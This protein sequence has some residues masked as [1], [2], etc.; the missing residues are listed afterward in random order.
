LIALTILKVLGA[1][2]L[3]DVAL[4]L[5]RAMQARMAGAMAGRPA[6]RTLVAPITD[7]VKLL[8][9]EGVV[10]GDVDRALFHLAPVLALC[11][12]VLLL[13]VIPFGPRAELFGVGADLQ[14]ADP[15][16]GVPFAWSMGVLA[17]AAVAF[18]SL[19]SNNKYAVLGGVR[20]AA[21][22]VAAQ[23]PL[24]LALVAVVLLSGSARLSE[25]VAAQDGTWL[26][27]I[28]RWNLFTQPVG[29]LLFVTGTLAL[30]DRRPLD[31]AA[32]PSELIA[33]YATEYGGARLALF[34]LA[35]STLL[36]GYSMMGAA[37]FLGGP[38]FP[39]LGAVPGLI[40]T[41]TGIA[42]FASKTA[43]VAVALVGLRYT[44]PRLRHDQLLRLGWRVLI[45][46]GLLN[47]AAT[48]VV[49][50]SA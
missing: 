17:L 19:A 31:T 18:G 50:A 4:V 24:A 11:A 28:P 32:A 40:G 30:A 3:F 14:I 13:A 42:V 20:A 8:A 38:G 37:C 41:A 9:K 16:A 23:I 7:F 33:G 22:V 27:W 29:L 35:E 44:M 47:L 26:G 10:P 48:A 12:S 2:A 25:I 6:R 1:L 34:G 46:L 36:L 15:R 5:L 43:V 21:Q 49:L 45:P 39:G